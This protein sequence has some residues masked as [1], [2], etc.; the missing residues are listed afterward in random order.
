MKG[1]FDY[2]NKQQHLN[3]NYNELLEQIYSNNDAKKRIFIEAKS[4]SST[5]ELFRFCLDLFFKG[6]VFC[7]GDSNRRV[8]IDNLSMEQIQ[9]VIDKL[10]YTG[11][12]TIIQVI[13]KDSSIHEHD[14]SSSLTQTE[15]VRKRAYTILQ[16]SVKRIDLYPEN[17]ELTNYNFKIKAGDNVFCIF[18]D[19]KS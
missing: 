18:F 17:D 1:I 2:E 14:D 12:M 8:E 13:L 5:K 3:V 4:L 19:I 16:E 10:S 9:D 7:N 15:Y 11:I 6:L